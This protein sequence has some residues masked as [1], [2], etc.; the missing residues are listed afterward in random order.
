MAGRISVGKTL[1]LVLL[2]L[3]VMSVVPMPAAA[4]E[5]SDEYN[6]TDS[7]DPTGAP[8]IDI[9]TEGN[10]HL[11]YLTN[12]G[13]D[14]DKL[15]DRKGGPS[16]NT[17]EGPVQVSPG[18][19]ES[20][21]GALAV[22]VDTAGRVH[23]AFSVMTSSDDARDVYYAQVSTSGGVSVAAKNIYSSDVAASALDIE[24]DSSGNA[25]I[26]WNERESPPT[27]MWVKVSS[28][29]SI[30]GSA[31]E[32][33]E[34]PGLNGDLYYPRI[35]VH[36]GGKTS[37]AWQQK[38]NLAARISIYFTLLSATGSV[39]EDP[40]EVVANPVI[41]L[42]NLEA[43]ADSNDNLH[44]TYV[45]SGSIMWTVVEDDGSIRDS[46]QI[47]SSLL[48][49]DGV[50]DISIAPNDDI[51]ISYQERENQISAPWIPYVRSYD[52]SEDDWSDPEQLTDEATGPPRAAAGN[53]MAGFTYT[54]SGDIRLV[55]VGADEA[56]RP[57]VAS[58]SYSPS[59]PSIGELVT[60]DGSGSSDPDDGDFVDMYYF[61]WGDGG[62]SG[63]QTSDRASHSYNSAGTFTASLRVRDSDGLESTSS[64]TVTVR[65]TSVPTNRAPTAVLTANPTTADTSQDVTFN[66]GSSSDPDGS[67]REYWF[68][69]GDGTNTGWVTTASVTHPYT[70]EGTYTATLKVRDDEGLQSENTGSA[71]V[72][73]VHTNQAPTATIDDISP[74]PAMVGQDITFTG[75]GTDT[76]GTIQ[77]YSWE[78]NLDSLIGSSATF[79][80]STMTAGTHTI[81][82]KVR[83]NGGDWSEEVTTTLVV[84][85]NSAFSIGDR[86]NLPE[87][88]YTDTLIEFRVVYTDLD[89]DRP[90]KMNLLY[91][92]SDGDWKEVELR[93]VDPVDKD[94]TDGKEYFFNK[95]F[96]DE[97]TW[98]YS[99]EFQNAKNPKKVT[100]SIE[101]KVKDPPGLF[102]AWEAAPATGALILVAIAMALVI[103]RRELY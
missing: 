49:E 6:V 18:T 48:G 7:N 3:L 59:D 54:R 9:D 23:I 64:D 29:G 27:I 97:G 20:Q 47:A 86:T 69:F 74:N 13:G 63:W 89:N 91:S 93:E 33:S 41:D 102:P 76:D 24:S 28:S 72:T 82:F 44:L 96:T 51:Y 58:L 77:V 8:R 40:V 85:A 94:Y 34:E 95:K 10:F 61:E 71:F 67:V 73:V 83:D 62:N 42:T 26:V 35:G 39:L 53:D 80:T 36:A 66:G 21:Y 98:K 75:T 19:V 32:I 11:V 84:K 56:N 5:V 52:D 16:G 25:Y 90:T 22:S 50:P 57:P 88:A 65:V 103:R 45:E 99:F 92:K 68:D 78:S 79:T 43:T 46:M 70:S 30:S 4:L 37:I 55:T 31:K 1:T 100:Q 2:A 87:Q 12:D 38:D 15:V 17:L 60:F 14:Y 81:T 101:F